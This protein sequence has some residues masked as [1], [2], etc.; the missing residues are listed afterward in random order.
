MV[1]LMN[2]FIPTVHTSR[3]CWF[4]ASETEPALENEIDSERQAHWLLRYFRGLKLRPRSVA[5]FSADVV[6]SYPQPVAHLVEQ[7]RRDPVRRRREAWERIMNCFYK[8]CF[9]PEFGVKRRKALRP[10]R[11]TVR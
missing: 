6:M 8:Q 7:A 4:C 3:P 5:L 10:L 9:R 11:P 2:N 1:V